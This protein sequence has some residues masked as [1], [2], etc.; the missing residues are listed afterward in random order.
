MTITDG[1]A[2][3][4]QTKDSAAPFNL[5]VPP[6]DLL[7][8]SLL[9]VDRRLGKVTSPQRDRMRVLL[10]SNLCQPWWIIAF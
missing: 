2:A 1:C 9:T 8:V 4:H 10:A 3:V 5:K 7:I 6:V